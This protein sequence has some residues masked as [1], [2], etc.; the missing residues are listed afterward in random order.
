MTQKWNLPVCFDT[1]DRVINIHYI[2]RKHVYACQI[3]TACK[4]RGKYLYA[5][6]RTQVCTQAF[7]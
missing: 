5:V 2:D 1:T 4:F 6:Y 3:K 7:V